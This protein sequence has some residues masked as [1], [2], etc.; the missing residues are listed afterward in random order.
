[1][2]A[3]ELY[4]LRK[5]ELTP[6]EPIAKFFRDDDRF[7]K[8]CQLLDEEHPLGRDY[9]LLAQIVGFNSGETRTLSK[10]KSPT[11]KILEIFCLKREK[12]DK[13]KVLE[14]FK[15]MV[16]TMEQQEVKALVENEIMVATYN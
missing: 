9:R 16:T 13:L 8:I 12:E 5:P 11:A 7:R 3:G 15:K 1:M 2:T 4:R 10:E 14:T 6:T